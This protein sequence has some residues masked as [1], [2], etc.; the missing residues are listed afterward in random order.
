MLTGALAAPADPYRGKRA[1]LQI[2]AWDAQTRI[3]H[4]IRRAERVTRSD[5]ALATG[6]SR[7]A[8]DQ[9]VAD[10]LD[11]R[12]VVRTALGPS[13][14]G[15]RPA[16]LAFNRDAGRVFGIQVGATGVDLALADLG[17]QPLEVRSEPLDIRQGPAATLSLIKALMDDVLSARG[18]QPRQILGIGLGLP[19]PIEFA[20]GRPVAPPLMPGWDGVDVP[21]LFGPEFTC[22]VYVDNDVNVMALGEQWAGAGRNV[23]NFI[24]IKVGTGIGAGIISEGSLHRGSDGCAGDIGHIEV[25]PEGPLCHCGNR[26]C[27]EAMAAGLAIA[28]IATDSARD[29]RSRFLAERMSAIGPLG[30]REVAEAAQYGDQA[31]LDIIRTSGR[32]IGRV[33]ASLV[34]FYNPSLIVISGG[35]SSSGDMFLAGIREA[36]YRRSTPLSTR[37][38]IIE[39]S[40]LGDAAGVIGAAL[41]PIDA[42][43]SSGR[44]LQDVTP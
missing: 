25:D 38:L 34:N 36:V 31:A 6:L 11:R 35:V 21:K 44:V 41:L 43:F 22:P 5:L 1:P 23:D 17:A 2:P 19:G 16:L 13:A 27:L 18:V 30:P 39:H 15:R 8:V 24:T 20:T 12:L 28:R 42:L 26:G 33:L 9:A 37:R 4:H 29:G 32:L 14:G 7:A 10:L 3:L 40:R